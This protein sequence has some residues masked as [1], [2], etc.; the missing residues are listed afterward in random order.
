MYCTRKITD[1]ISY[2]GASDR[3]I[4]LFENVYPVPEGASYNSYF[5]DDSKT[6]VI[7]TVD[8][9]VS[10]QFFENL[11]HM[12]AGRAL[13][14]VIVNHMEP[15]HAASLEEL[16]MRYPEVTVVCNDKIKK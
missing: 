9:A 3:R 2:I 8:R 11:E 7:D 10:K 16:I 6:A 15:D 14:Y 12:L 5:I 13:D 1:K 4:A